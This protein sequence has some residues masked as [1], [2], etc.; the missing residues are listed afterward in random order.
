MSSHSKMVRSAK[1][2]AGGVLSIAEPKADSNGNRGSSNG[3][4]KGDL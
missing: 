2:A 4:R 1:A 3:T